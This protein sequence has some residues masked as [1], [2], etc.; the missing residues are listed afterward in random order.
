M[1]NRNGFFQN[2]LKTIRKTAFRSSIRLVMA[3][4]GRIGMVD[5]QITFL[6]KEQ[7]I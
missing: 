2:W 3:G 7:I 1:G 5:F 6:K 4:S